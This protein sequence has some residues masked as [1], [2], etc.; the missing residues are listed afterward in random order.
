MAD[1]LSS[2]SSLPRLL[3]SGLQTHLHMGSL[4]V[5][6]LFGS[7]AAVFMVAFCLQSLLETLFF[8]S[9]LAQAVAWLANG[10]LLTKMYQHLASQ[11]AVILAFN[12]DRPGQ[13]QKAPKGQEVQQTV[14]TALVRTTAADAA[15]QPLEAAQGQ[16]VLEP[17]PTKLESLV[18]EPDKSVQK[19]RT[20]PY[21]FELIAELVEHQFDE[22]PGKVF[23][24]MVHA[25]DELTC[26]TYRGG[27]TVKEYRLLA[28]VR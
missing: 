9:A 19:E 8:P 5:L 18:E 22:L 27:A 20:L 1:L 7:T 3:D 21:P 26:Q 11:N 10:L 12:T 24:K 14:A 13:T 2:L 28:K 15:T 4:Q 25:A 17:A 6:Q 23:L 16:A